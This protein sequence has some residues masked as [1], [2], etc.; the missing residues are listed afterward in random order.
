MLITTRSRIRSPSATT[1]PRV[2]A[3]IPHPAAPRTPRGAMEVR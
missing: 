2:S 1:R 3:L